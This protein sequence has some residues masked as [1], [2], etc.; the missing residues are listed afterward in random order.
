MLCKEVIS[1]LSATKQEIDAFRQDVS[2]K[3]QDVQNWISSTK[4]T[5]LET[6]KKIAEIYKEGICTEKANNWE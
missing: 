1:E 5:E 3:N 2:K 6:W 4:I